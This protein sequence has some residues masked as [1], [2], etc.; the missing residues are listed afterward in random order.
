MENIN[1]QRLRELCDEMIKILN[2]AKEELNTQY[3]ELIREYVTKN[4]LILD[5]VKQKELWRSLSKA[6]GANI[7]LGKQLKE[8]GVSYGYIAS[9]KAWK[10][11][12]IDI[13][14]V[15]EDLPF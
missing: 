7:G 11:M 6:T 8:I 10:D 5:E 9:N 15:P 1:V 3:K 12:R 4:G 2:G 13:N 14:E